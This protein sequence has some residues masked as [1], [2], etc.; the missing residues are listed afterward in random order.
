[1]KAQITSIAV[2]SPVRSVRN[3]RHDIIYVGRS[4]GS[5]GKVSSFI[6]GDL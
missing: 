4:D 2:A 6:I 1:M 3:Q 5:I